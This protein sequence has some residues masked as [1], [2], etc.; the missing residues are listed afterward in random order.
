MRTFSVKVD[1]FIQSNEPPSGLCYPTCPEGFRGIGPVCW[2]GTQSKGRGVGQVR[3]NTCGGQGEQV[4]GGLCY[5]QCPAT[6]KPIGPVC[7][8][9]NCP[10]SL[11]NKCG[12]LCLAPGQS[13]NEYISEMAVRIFSIITNAIAN[14]ISLVGVSAKEMQLPLSH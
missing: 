11:P 1:S 7:W 6:F 2:K 12:A 14:P 10:A 9:T 3:R 13:C 5:K 8:D 4:D